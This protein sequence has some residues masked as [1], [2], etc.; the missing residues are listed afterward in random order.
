MGNEGSA[1]VEGTRGTKFKVGDRVVMGKSQL[2]TWQSRTNL[3]A[4]SLHLLPAIPVISAVAAATISINPLTA[5]RLL[6]DFVP[7]TVSSSVTLDRPIVSSGTLDRPQQWVIQNAANSAVG[8]AVIQMAKLFRV[9]TINLVRD[10]C[11]LVLFHFVSLL[12]A[13]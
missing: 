3:P 12:H 2:S 5:Y 13:S 9:K 8:E 7:L 4:D 11:V 1:I 10:R 6:S